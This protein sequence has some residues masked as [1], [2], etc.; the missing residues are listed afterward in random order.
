MNKQLQKGFIQPFE[1]K[2]IDAKSGF[3][4]QAFTRY[5]VM[6]SDRDRG[7]K[8]MFT[9]TW[10]EN[11][12][13]IR[14]I[15][16]HDYTIPL[17]APLRFYDENDY[18][19][20]ES[21]LGTNDDA[22]DFKK[23]VESNLIREASYGYTIIKADKQSDGSQDLLEVRLWEVSSLTGW[24]ANEY[25]PVLA[26]Q[27]GKDKA[28]A[29]TDYIERYEN[30]VSFCAKSTATDKTLQQLEL[31]RDQIKSF[32]VNL[33]GS[34]EAEDVSLQPHGDVKSDETQEALAFLT[35]TNSNLLQKLK[36]GR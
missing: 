2:D 5:N 9:K 24:G 8:G 29:L 26:F 19:I 27:K 18:A 3:F 12:P 15:L 17:G 16:N 10:A 7:R 20:M 23:M 25:T 22:E 14:H 21:Q 34:T 30:L 31:E 32:L 35:L 6:D 13:R 28:K 33:L 11:F 4:K 36:S 1:V